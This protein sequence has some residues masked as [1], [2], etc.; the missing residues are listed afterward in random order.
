[1][2]NPRGKRLR[3]T[4]C[5]LA[6]E[7][8]GGDWHK[9][10][11]AAAALE[12]MHNFTLIH[13][14]IQDKS[15]ERRHR[16]SVWW[17]WGAA[18]GINA[19]DAIYA[20]TQLALCKLESRG[21]P[22]EKVTASSRILNET[23]LRICEGQFLDISYEDHLDI[24]TTDYLNMVDGKTAQLFQC[25]LQLGAL[26]G[27]E[28]ETLIRQLALFGRELGI[29]FQIYDDIM[30]IWG[31]EEDTGKPCG[32]DIMERKKTPPIIYALNQAGKETGRRLADIYRKDELSR[33]DLSVVLE[34]LESSA[35]REYTEGL[36][37]QYH[38]RALDI[39]KGTGLA[40]T[41][42]KELRD[43]ADFILG[44]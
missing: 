14:D 19:G 7:S 33:D 5:L 36:K 2:E 41:R 26:L 44:E 39:L 18:Q 38:Q 10:L 16:P 3:P 37:E 8:V 42:Q 6:C 32:S 34:I 22:A 17:V 35:A 20:L 21:I 29:A 15:P 12:V 1:M 30:G 40:T 24:T 28:D 4:F 25:S 31:K 11:P 9:V 27:T 13:D 23:C 43:V